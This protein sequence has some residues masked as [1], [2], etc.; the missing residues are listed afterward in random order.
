MSGDRQTGNEDTVEQMEVYSP[1]FSPRLCLSLVCAQLI[2]EARSFL[3]LLRLP[4]GCC[5]APPRG[6][7]WIEDQGRKLN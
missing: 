7:P 3:Y 6:A 2:A 5:N 1:L 4:G